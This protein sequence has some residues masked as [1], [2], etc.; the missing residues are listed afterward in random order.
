MKMIDISTKTYPNS[1]VM[2][3][4]DDFLRL[5][6]WKW[7]PQ[8][9]RATFYAV[10]NAKKPRTGLILMHR[11]ILKI[12]T[13]QCVDHIDHNGLNNTRGNLRTATRAQ[14]AFNSRKKHTNT[15][16]FIGVRWSQ[17]CKKWGA[18]IKINGKSVSLGYGDNPEAMARIRD[19]AAIKS[20]GEFACLNF[21]H[22]KVTMENQANFSHTGG[23][24]MTP[25]NPTAFPAEWWCNS[26]QGFRITTYHQKDLIC[27]CGHI[28]ATVK[29]CTDNPPEAA[30]PPLAE[31]TA[32][33]D[34]ME[35]KA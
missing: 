22:R 32:W 30:G 6:K 2:V 20:Q 23:G 17:A 11:E 4:D 28:I 3:D 16:G 33:I 10:R 8:K 13:G 18:H 25:D 35:G 21:D 31:P 15:S 19:D 24:S 5:N 12:A 7:F 14:N 29:F 9:A 1:F 34:R 26:C 27:G